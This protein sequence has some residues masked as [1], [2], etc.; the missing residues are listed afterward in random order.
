LQDDLKTGNVITYQDKKLSELLKEFDSKM[1]TKLLIECVYVSCSKVVSANQNDAAKSRAIQRIE[2]ILKLLKENEQFVQICLKHI[3]DFQSEK[4]IYL[5]NEEKAKSWF[6]NEVAKLSNVI[7]YGTLQK[8]CRNYIEKSMSHFFAGMIAFIDTNDNLDLLLSP[9]PTTLDLWHRIFQDKTITSLAYE[10]NFLQTNGLEKSEFSFMSSASSS[11]KEHRVKLPFSWILVNDFD[12]IINSGEKCFSNFKTADTSNF[13]NLY[14]IFAT[15]KLNEKLVSLQIEDKR[16]FIRLYVHD[17]ILLKSKFSFVSSEHLE[18][19][20]KRVVYFCQEKIRLK[21]QSD[22]KFLIGIHLSYD[23]LQTELHLLLK[24][25]ELKPDISV[26]LLNKCVDVEAT[27]LCFSASRTV[28]NDLN[29]LDKDMRIPELKSWFIKVKKF[30]YLIENFINMFPE[31]SVGLDFTDFRSLWE[32]VTLTKLFIEN[33]CYF[34]ETF[35]KRC[36]TLWGYDKKPIDFKTLESFKS[37]HK[38]CKLIDTS[39]KTLCFKIAVPCSA[40]GE[41]KFENLYQSSKCKCLICEDCVKEQKRTRKCILCTTSLTEDEHYTVQTN[42]NKDC[43]EKYSKFK[44]AMNSL[45]FEVIY[46]LCFNNCH[47]DFNSSNLPEKDLIN[48]IISLV[49]PQGSFQRDPAVFDLNL[50]PALKAYLFKLLLDYCSDDLE[51]QINELFGQ[52]KDYLRKYYEEQDLVNLKLIYINLIEDN[53]YSKQISGFDDDA[54]SSFLKREIQLSNKIFDNLFQYQHE[55]ESAFQ[56]LQSYA[57]IKFCLVNLSK[58]IVKFD[59]NDRSHAELNNKAMEFFSNHKLSSNDWPR[60]FL[61]KQIY[62]QHGK[63]A[64]FEAY[65]K[66][67]FKWILPQ[68]LVNNLSNNL[69]DDYVICGKKYLSVRNSL[70]DAVLVGD[71]KEFEFINSHDLYYALAIFKGIT[72]ANSLNQT[73]QEAFYEHIKKSKLANF[74]SIYEMILLKT[75]L[76]LE[77]ISNE[78]YRNI[79]LLIMHIY[80]VIYSSDSKLLSPYKKLLTTPSLFNASY[81]PTILHDQEYE[82]F[83]TFKLTLTATDKAGINNKYFKCP[84]GHYYSIGDCTKPA[85]VGKCATCGEAIGGTGYKLATGNTEA[86]DLVDKTPQGYSL[87]ESDLRSDS[88]DNIRNMG[89]IQTT[90]MRLILHAVLYINSLKNEQDLK[91]L[92]NVTAVKTG[93]FFSLQI[94]KDLKVLSNSLQRNLDESLLLIHHILDHIVHKD[95]SDVSDT[96]FDSMLLTQIDRSTFE[97]LFCQHYLSPVITNNLQQVM[98]DLLTRIIDEKQNAKDEDQL[99]KIIHEKLEPKQNASTRSD[100]FIDERLCWSYRIHV[101]VENMLNVLNSNSDNKQNYPLL[102]QFMGKVRELE[103]LKYLPFICKMITMLTSMFNRQVCRSFGHEYTVRTLSSQSKL[104]EHEK[105]ILNSG[106]RSLLKVWKM[107]CEILSTKHIPKIIGSLNL[108]DTCL[109]GQDHS[110]LPISYLLPNQSKEGRY[111]YAL[112]YYLAELQTEFVKF[113]LSKTSYDE[114]PAVRVDIENVNA[115]DCIAFSVDKEV[116]Q[117]VCLNSNYSLETRHTLGVDYN[118][119]RIEALIETKLLTGKKVFNINSIPFI[120]YCDEINDSTLFEDLDRKLNQEELST[121]EKQDLIREFNQPIQLT[122]LIRKLRIIIDFIVTCGCSSTNMKI[123]EY[124]TNV[125]KMDL[126]QNFH[127]TFAN[128]ETVYLQ[129]ILNVL[130]LKRAILLTE[131]KQD[132]FD[133]LE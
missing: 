21:N 112:V 11:N 23:Y 90:I 13:E 43:L 93:E 107:T 108:N 88:P 106:A 117:Y 116:L 61:L 96:A 127:A 86:P 41:N 19:V 73:E 120:Q 35:Y 77:F 2:I 33:I 65:A 7:K 123:V 45:F 103:A 3:A 29:N 20:K 37:F 28:S 82:I 85:T 122:E 78:K 124:T 72:L 80:F 128:L 129:S 121:K 55:S 60:F 47:Q 17:F 89:S 92:M 125:L 31:S 83:S 102:C 4:E 99:S 91:K 67:H 40:C 111:V 79:S 46:T 68:F 15:S 130:F 126:T 110:E 87:I 109:K 133:Q 36:I 51:H 100:L 44:S 98:T 132:P 76:P 84:K 131:H 48:G 119:K 69:N 52:N 50:N 6:V 59:L 25:L 12:R 38:F 24:F 95:V 1:L 56:L 5:N 27:N 64:I 34:D 58:L 53:F 101:N 54:A 62:K 9:N 26:K 14:E 113:Y 16:E 63:Q 30:S 66:E 32:K 104:N 74:A 105:E 49:L 70:Q 94:L 57:Q 115:A 42:P 118:F 8:S 97:N 22:F 10:K 39:Q 81:I 71:L 114:Q 75:N 18:L